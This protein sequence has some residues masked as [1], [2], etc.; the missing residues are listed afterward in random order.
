MPDNLKNAPPTETSDHATIGGYSPN[1]SPM[2]QLNPVGEGARPGSSSPRRRL[3][4]GAAILLLSAT[5]PLVLLVLLRNDAVGQPPP[6]ADAEQARQNYEVAVEQWREYLKTLRG[7]NVRY[8]SAGRSQSMALRA[9]W[10]QM[11]EQGEK[12]IAPALRSAALA[13]FQAAPNRD[14]QLAQLLLN[15]LSDDIER[16]F[17]QDAFDLGSALIASGHEA[18]EIHDHTGKAAYAIHK[19]D[20]ARPALQR[21]RDLGVLSDRSRSMLLELDEVQQLWEQ[22]VEQREVDAQSDL[23]RVRIVTNRGDVV[24]ELFEDQAPDTVGNFIHLVENG[25][26]E[27]LIFHRVL[28]GFMA[29]TG[30]PNGDGTGGPGYRVYCETDKPDHRNHFRG[31]LSMAKGDAKHTGGSQFFIT[32]QPTP[33]LNG[34]HT[35]FGRVIEGMEVVDRIQRRDP[36]NP[37]VRDPDRIE[38][39]EVI[40]KRDHT[41]VP[42]KV[43]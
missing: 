36:E 41:Y 25:F 26:Y 24:V 38:R 15:M 5:A 32:F 16:D 14:P 37:D 29:Q 23:P 21:A 43:R 40:R 10:D 27:N 39:A 20:E 33:H 30:C 31:S 8:L 3:G 22:E 13:A 1:H 9:E 7:I 12:D 18:A 19:F 42:R 6:S 11:M 28:A 4:L 34:L 17:Y 35:V 2:R